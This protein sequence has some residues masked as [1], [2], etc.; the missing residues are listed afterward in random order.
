MF[1]S[2]TKV[3]Q[4]S[5]QS[6][7]TSKAA[8]SSSDGRSMHS[9]PR[10]AFSEPVEPVMLYHYPLLEEAAPPRELCDFAMPMGCRLHH[11]AEEANLQEIFYGQKQSSR[12]GRSFTF[13]LENKTN[14][15]PPPHGDAEG[16]CDVEE[17]R[18]RAEES[19]VGTD[20]LYGFCVIHSRYLN[21]NGY[22]SYHVSESPRQRG[23]R[24]GLAEQ[25]LQPMSYDFEAP[26]CYAFISKFPFH[27][28]FFRV[29]YAIINTERLTRMEMMEALAEFAC[30]G[31]QA[32]GSSSSGGMTN[33][34]RQA[35][36][37]L[38]RSMLEEI[39]E[40]L[41]KV[42]VPRYGDTI[43]FEV[44]P[45]VAAIEYLRALPSSNFG[46]H[47]LTSAEWALPVLLA[48]VPF[49]TLIW[50][51]G[52]ALCEA[53]IIVVGTEVGM[54]SSAIAGLLALIHPL[55]WV[56]P[57]IPILPLKHF[58][59]VESPVPLI[60]GL[61]IDVCAAQCV[62]AYNILKLCNDEDNGTVTAVL[63]VNMRDVFISSSNLPISRELLLPGAEALLFKLHDRYPDTAPEDV[64]IQSPTKSNKRPLAEPNFTISAHNIEKATYFQ[65]LL[66]GHIH[67]IIEMSIEQT[68]QQQQRLLRSICSSA[69][70]AQLA[71]KHESERSE[72][73]GQA[74]DEVKDA[75]EDHR[76]DSRR[77]SSSV[78]SQTASAHRTSFTAG[79]DAS[80]HSN[81]TSP[82]NL[83][84]SQQLSAGGSFARPSEHGLLYGSRSHLVGPQKSINVQ[85]KSLRWSEVGGIILGDGAA[86]TSTS[87]NWVAT[88][89]SQ[90]GHSENNSIHSRPRSPAPHPALQQ[91][92]SARMIP[93]AH[94][95]DNNGA[96]EP[97][98]KPREQPRKKRSYPDL[99]D[100][101]GNSKPY[102]SDDDEHSRDS[103]DDSAD[104]GDE[105]LES[106]EADD[107]AI[108]ESLGGVQL[109]ANDGDVTEPGRPRGPVY[110]SDKLDLARPATHSSEVSDTSFRQQSPAP[111]G[112]DEYLASF[113][114]SSSLREAV[115][116]QALGLSGQSVE[117]EPGDV[118][119]FLRRFT[120]T[121][122]YSEYVGD[123]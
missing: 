8:P 31:D 71:D 19:G 93:V 23:N 60:A 74:G 72:G 25:P 50:I 12:S 45:S 66:N 107:L 48:W 85:I 4:P 67:T 64:A 91:R 7:P 102:D 75:S 106:M 121:Q 76:S 41:I 49:E 42:R 84:Y 38:Q 33:I 98:T 9:R 32:A 27:E 65:E 24:G 36:I 117:G 18:L 47:S 10:T 55:K 53:K 122:L 43:V 14:A 87:T 86:S 59:F 57:L 110:T 101:H 21:V 22:G 29:I 63:D 15:I 5:H 104:R 58:E 78:H 113:A 80:V 6:V 111:A 112:A 114:T 16:A 82:R 46:E 94:S 77:H 100:K 95:G 88:Q 115:A 52:L 35:Y 97:I 34:D 3:S 109:F 108:L 120:L 17:L 20:R 1:R 61:V 79:S 103:D 11:I 116:F 99:L 54:I 30:D 28:F 118:D 51:I 119:A 13:I 96:P 37:Y 90:T 39:L 123:G 40:K 68:T 44:S 2:S 73:E 70:I 81:N 92:L 89:L 26:V 62:D 105:D 69:S 56:A 83:P